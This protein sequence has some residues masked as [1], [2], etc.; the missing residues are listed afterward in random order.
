[1]IFPKLPFLELFY[2]HK[3]HLCGSLETHLSPLGA[4]EKSIHS[5]GKYSHNVLSLGNASL[6][7]HG[8]CT[9]AFRWQWNVICKQMLSWEL[10][11]YPLPWQWETMYLYHTSTKGQ[12]KPSHLKT[13]WCSKP[14]SWI[15]SLQLWSETQRK[16]VSSSRKIGV[17]WISVRKPEGRHRIGSMEWKGLRILEKYNLST[18]LT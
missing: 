6:I 13:S 1:M 11:H 4:D 18:E 9:T 15:W 10:S 17:D 3:N 7:A 16:V 2:Q 8:S 12:W 14:N 5:T